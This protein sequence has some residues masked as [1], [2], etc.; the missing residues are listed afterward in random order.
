MIVIDETLFAENVV[1]RNQVEHTK[2]ERSVLGYIR[3][4]FIVMLRFSFQVSHL[5]A[6]IVVLILYW[7]CRRLR[8]CI[9]YWITVPVVNYSF[10][11]D[12]PVVSLKIAPNSMRLR[13]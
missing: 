7:L 9:S 8:N 11:W 1:K 4:P 6:Q 5:F 2:T 12:A 10:I 3:H 13:S